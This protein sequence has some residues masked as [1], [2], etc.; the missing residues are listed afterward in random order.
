DDA[1]RVPDRVHDAPTLSR[2]AFARPGFRP[3]ERASCPHHRA[4]GDARGPD[5]AGYSAAIGPAWNG[6]GSARSA[7]AIGAGHHLSSHS[8]NRP[9]SFGK[10]CSANSLVLYF[11]S[12]LPMLPNCKSIIKWPTLRSV[13][14]SVNCSTTS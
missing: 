3:M 12:S 6:A 10:T 11:A 14:T 13:A 5:A 7:A 4:G 8:E 9:R 1:D 2:T